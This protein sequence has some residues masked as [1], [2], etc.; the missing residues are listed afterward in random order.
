MQ[1]GHAA[2]IRPVEK[3]ER[4][5]DARTGE[6]AGAPDKDRAGLRGRILGTL[7]TT[8][9][10][11]AVLMLLRSLGVFELLEQAKDDQE[12]FVATFRS[13][14]AYGVLAFLGILAIRPLTLIP[15]IYLAP[16]AA[17]LFGPFV[18]GLIKVLGES[19]AACIAFLVTRRGLRAFFT[20]SEAK[21]GKGFWHRVGRMVERRGF[22]IVLALRLNLLLPYDALNYGL[23]LS[24]VRF[25]PYLFG[26]VLGILPGTLAYVAL[27]GVA[28]EG[29]WILTALLIAG[30]VA[31]LALSIPLAR[32]L[33]QE[34]ADEG[35]EEGPS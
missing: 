7:L 20:R 28:M 17:L 2:I 22:L 12:G 16:V 33:F 15:G 26:T 24:P 13:W 14:G 11:V 18:G 34:T 5:I 25:W 21:E 3:R 8:V 31:M 32:D 4:E 27:S 1:S 30:I 19:I 10:L 6:V 35:K 9:L 23:G 29:N